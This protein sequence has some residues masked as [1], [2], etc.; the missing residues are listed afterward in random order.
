MKGNNI[1][2][3]L[4]VSG[5][6]QV[7]VY[8]CDNKVF[9]KN[10]KNFWFADPFLIEH[11]GEK[12]LFVEA[13][14]KKKEIG[15][16]G[17]FRS[18]DNFTQLSLLITKKYHLS[19]P[20]VFLFENNFYMIPE[21][22]ENGT[23][24]LY[25]FN[26]FPFSI[27]FKNTIMKGNYVDTSVVLKFEK[28]FLLSTYDNK[29]KKNIFFLYD[30]EKQQCEIIKTFDDDLHVLRP[31][32]NAY[33]RNGRLFMPFQNCRKKYGENI[34]IKELKIL[35]KDIE[36]C[37]ES[38]TFIE[39][40]KLILNVDRVHTLNILNDHC[41]TL[42]FMIEKIS[43]LKPIKMLKRKIRRFFHKKSGK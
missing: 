5:D 37:E 43:L 19:Y 39:E 8:H 10:T 36:I 2:S 34:I 26:D 32:G 1:F 30:M 3:K 31:A 11:N 25:I 15:R 9:I 33:V 21:T 14:E 28:S 38:H 42:D 7:L 35:N 40:N 18:S 29:S 41:L 4:F 27:S 12:F 6:W 17:F 23:I 16:I 13:F 22:S 20:N 24:D